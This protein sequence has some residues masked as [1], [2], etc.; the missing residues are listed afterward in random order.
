MKL[1]PEIIESWIADLAKSKG[2]YCRMLR[3]WRNLTDESKEDYC[4]YL[5]RK[6][7]TNSLD[8][9]LEVEC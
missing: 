5:N 8:F 7:I 2:F 6:G 3:Y 4:E 9:V 1:T